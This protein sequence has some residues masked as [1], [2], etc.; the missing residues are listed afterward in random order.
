MQM[1]DN[2]ARWIHDV[3]LRLLSYKKV[4][5]Y[6]LDF[7]APQMQ[8]SPT[9]PEC[10]MTAG[11][12]LWG[13]THVLD[14]RFLLKDNSTSQ[15]SG[16]TWVSPEPW[17]SYAGQRTQDIQG[18]WNLNRISDSIESNICLLDIDFLICK[19]GRISQA[20]S[21]N[22]CPPTRTIYLFTPAA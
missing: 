11:Q 9:D 15:N 1:A 8:F 3:R 12:L 13:H 19:I 6:K 18:Q 14:D 2:K 21:H 10:L 20:G 22:A 16:A 17:E 7:N 5:P 4:I